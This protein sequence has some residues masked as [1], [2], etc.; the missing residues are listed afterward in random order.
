MVH[1]SNLPVYWM[2]QMVKRLLIQ[3]LNLLLPWLNEGCKLSRLAVTLG[4]VDLFSNS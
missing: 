4:L 2:V 1:E 3:I